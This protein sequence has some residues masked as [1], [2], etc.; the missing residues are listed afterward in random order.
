[1]AHDEDLPLS[2]LTWLGGERRLARAVGRPMRKFLKIE[3]ASGILLMVATVTALVWANSPWSD[4]YHDI[5]ETHIVFE[6]GDLVHLDEPLEAWIN[7]ALMAI[8]FFVV[9]LEIKRELVVGELREPRAA[10][11]PAIAAIGGMVVPALIYV[12]FNPATPEF[13]DGDIL[14]MQWLDGS[15]G[16]AAAGAIVSE[17]TRGI[18]AFVLEDRL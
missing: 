1:M 4:S 11:L 16:V 10:A 9:G 6:I 15:V 17:T 12:A 13:D 3:A 14:R 8:F 2:P 18:E 5:L 7:D